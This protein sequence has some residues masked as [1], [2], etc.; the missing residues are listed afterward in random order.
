MILKNV[1]SN[2][3]PVATGTLYHDITGEGMIPLLRHLPKVVVAL[4]VRHRACR[5][6]LPPRLNPTTNCP[7]KA[8]DFRALPK[9]VPQ[10]T[11]VVP[12]R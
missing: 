5:H 7:V 3:R 9:K 8:A 11:A 12:L 2:P 10:V 1:F 4:E 6:F